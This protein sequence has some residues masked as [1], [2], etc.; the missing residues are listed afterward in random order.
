ALVRF[1]AVIGQTA[2][3]FCCA[4]PILRGYRTN[5]IAFLLRLS[6]SSRLSDKQCSKRIALVRF[7]ETATFIYLCTC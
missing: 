2:S 6:D 4:C 7:F 1:F 3:L 5:G